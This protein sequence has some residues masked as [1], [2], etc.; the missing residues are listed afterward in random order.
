MTSLF[1]FFVARKRSSRVPA[2]KVG[3]EIASA[4]SWTLP[5]IGRSAPQ[6][7]SGA[8][9]L[10][11]RDL[12]LREER[13]RKKKVVRKRPSHIRLWDQRRK[14]LSWSSKRTRMGYVAH[15]S[16]RLWKPEPL[17]HLRKKKDGTAVPRLCKGKKRLPRF[18]RVFEPVDA[19]IITREYKKFCRGLAPTE[20]RLGRI[21]GPRKQ[22]MYYLLSSFGYR[23]MLK[24]LLSFAY[25]RFKFKRTVPQAELDSERFLL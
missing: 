18:Q 10:A 2:S 23:R 25:A 4:I 15:F 5:K 7:C 9:G 3:F 16:Q 24:S 14:A 19:C 17:I 11:T 20:K 21:P 12:P 22:L 1:V 13:K 6:H 8:K